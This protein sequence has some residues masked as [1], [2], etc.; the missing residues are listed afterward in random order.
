MTRILLTI[1]LA[2][3]IVQGQTN[4]ASSAQTSHAAQ[5]QQAKPATKPL[6]A[7]HNASGSV[8][9]T[10]AVITIHGICSIAEKADATISTD[11]C[12]TTVTK[13]KFDSLIA[14]TRQPG[15]SVPPSTLMYVAKGYTA[16]LTYADAA[17][18][19]GLENDPT[20]KTLMELSRLETLANMYRMRITAE[21]K[22]TQQEVDDYYKQHL[23]DYDEFQMARIFIPTSDSS[24][25]D[26]EAFA[27]KAE[28]LTREIHDRAAKGEDPEKL[29][30]EAYADLGVANPPATNVGRIRRVGIPASLLPEISALKPDEVT[31][32]EDQGNGHTIYKLI[33][34]RTATID[35]VSDEI[36][37]QLSAKKMAAKMNTVTDATKT[38]FNEKYFG[39]N[40]EPTP[41]P[42]GA[43]TAPA[44]STPATAAPPKNSP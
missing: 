2:A 7:T 10:D 28:E 19:A 37:Q 30:K 44:S 5:A 24:A 39:T 3:A 21:T 8:A 17:R 12:T 40:G 42:A 16:M 22:A 34:R 15:A 41:H 13:E 36:S 14:A 6:A 1:A 18:K 31:K 20:Y 9:P 32:P 29:E 25:K 38:D 33:S 35:E 27:K 43:Q 26:K 4:S 11:P 23:S